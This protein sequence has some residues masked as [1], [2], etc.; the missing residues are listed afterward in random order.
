M[1]FPEVNEQVLPCGLRVLSTHSPSASMAEVRLAIP[2]PSTAVDLAAALV[3]VDSLPGGGGRADEAENVLGPG[4]LVQT[5]YDHRWLR[6]GASVPATKLPE[7]IALVFGALATPRYSA[8]TCRGAT[9]RIIQRNI[10][11]R[12]HPQIIARTALGRHCYGDDF[13]AVLPEPSALSAVTPEDVTRL[14]RDHLVPDRALLVVTGGADQGRTSKALAEA[15]SS[16]SADPGRE[17]PARGPELKDAGITLAERQSTGQSDITLIARSLPRTDP[18]FPALSIAN[19]VFGGYPASRLVA[20]LREEKG[21][22]YAVECALDELLEDELIMIHA[23]MDPYDA[24]VVL[25]E[26]QS[27]LARFAA[28][29]P[30]AAEIATA[31]EYMLGMLY[32]SAASQAGLAELLFSVAPLGVGLDWLLSLP[33]VLH[34]VTTDQVAEIARELYPPDRFS[35]VVVGERGVLGAQEFDVPQGAAR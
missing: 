31:R 32:Q 11:A 33:Q 29:P 30:T 19:C 24:P 13:P 8:D 4:A 6:I 20:R 21:L 3:M 27:E 28:E 26:I 16:W 5:T 35:G 7:L 2:M 15:T 34:D 9:R 18:R 14:H 17:A 12:S 10:M 25:R 23:G 22:V 1:T